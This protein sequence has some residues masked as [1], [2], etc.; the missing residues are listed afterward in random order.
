MT[1]LTILMRK[2]LDSVESH[3]LLTALPSPPALTQWWLITPSPM[4][5]ENIG[6]SRPVPS[7]P[8]SPE[9]GQSQQNIM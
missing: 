6:F 9:S 1:L 3:P 4:E 2:Q 7:S 5:F 8:A